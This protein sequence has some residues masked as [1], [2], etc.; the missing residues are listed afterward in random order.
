MSQSTMRAFPPAAFPI[1][2]EAT[3][4]EQRNLFKMEHFRECLFNITNN[5]VIDPTESLFIVAEPELANAI[6]GLPAGQAPPPEIK[7]PRE[8]TAEESLTAAGRI[9]YAQQLKAFQDKVSFETETKK[10]ILNTTHQNTSPT[11]TSECSRT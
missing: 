7:R 2:A 4:S 8:L 3:P 5:G 11:P 10:Y 1:K 9:T 6:L